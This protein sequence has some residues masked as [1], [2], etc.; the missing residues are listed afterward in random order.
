[1]SYPIIKHIPFGFKEE[2][3]NYLKDAY[4]FLIPYL[5]FYFLFHHFGAV[6]R[7]VRRFT[8]FFIGEMIFS[9]FS[10]LFITLG[11][12]FWKDY[13]VIPISISLSQ[14]LAT[15]Y[16]LFVGR[17]FLHIKLYYDKT[18]SFILKHFFYLSALYGILHIFNF[19]NIAF[20]STLG[21]KAVSAL[22]YGFMIANIPKFV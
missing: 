21:E 17:E 2:S 7:S 9:F 8:Q 3:L 20:S 6:L 12:F 15:L 10:F 1:M 5:I 11:L 18:V 19:I 14:L 16:M 22:T 4:F 13:R